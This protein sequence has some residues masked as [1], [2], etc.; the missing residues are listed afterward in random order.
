MRLW[1]TQY[2]VI[3]TSCHQKGP[4][5]PFNGRDHGCA[6]SLSSNWPVTSIACPL[7]STT[8]TWI[9]ENFTNVHLEFGRSMLT[10][11]FIF[12]RIQPAFCFTK[13]VHP[14]RALVPF[15]I[16][17]FHVCF[18]VSYHITI[19]VTNIKPRV[20]ELPKLCHHRRCLICAQPVVKGPWTS[21]LSFRLQPP[22]K[23]P[24]AQH[25]P[26]RSYF[27]NQ[28]LAAFCRAFVCPVLINRFLCRAIY[29]FYKGVGKCSKDMAGCTNTCKQS[30]ALDDAQGC[31]RLHM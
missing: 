27:E 21:S 7:S 20:G 11:P 18:G 22:L 9:L 5:S 26:Q 30:S 28:S 16:H 12:Q 24:C 23:H 1:Y 8:F 13:V 15:L 29:I 19:D 3:R 10:G 25:P 6:G 14:R 2:S 4:A 31:A 17:Y